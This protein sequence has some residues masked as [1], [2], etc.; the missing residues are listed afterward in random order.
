MQLQE[1]EIEAEERIAEMV[2]PLAGAALLRE[3]KGRRL[4]PLDL[5]AT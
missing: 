5:P 1:A 4:P 2:A 3:R